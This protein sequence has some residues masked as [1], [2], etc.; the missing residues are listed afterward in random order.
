[1]SDIYVL[2]STMLNWI[3]GDDYCAQVITVENHGRLSYPI[4][5]KH[6]FHPQ[7][8]EVATPCSNVFSLG[9]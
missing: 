6:L 2:C 7:Q 4:F 3:F 5:I 1:M 8:L 9:C